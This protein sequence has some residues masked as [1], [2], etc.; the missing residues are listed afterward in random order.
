[1]TNKNIINLNVLVFRLKS[2]VLAL[3]LF[4]YHIKVK[5]TNKLIMSKSSKNRS[6]TEK[7]LAPMNKLN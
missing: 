4:D 6:K 3:I 7:Q 1:M 2:S 5:K